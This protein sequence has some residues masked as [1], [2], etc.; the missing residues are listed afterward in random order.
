M[1]MKGNFIGSKSKAPWEYPQG[2]SKD[3]RKEGKANV[4][5]LHRYEDKQG[6]WTN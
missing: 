4:R 2:L 5:Q 6:I 1:R 3:K